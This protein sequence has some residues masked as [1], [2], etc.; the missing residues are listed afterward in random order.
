MESAGINF[1]AHENLE[2]RLSHFSKALLMR[3]PQQSVN[4]MPEIEF[5][6]MALPKKF[7]EASLF[8]CP[9]FYKEMMELRN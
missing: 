2:K 9:Q 3:V 4:L 6:K 5:M 1:K 8:L 7:G